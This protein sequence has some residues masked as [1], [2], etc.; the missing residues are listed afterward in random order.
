M[1]FSV[2]IFKLFGAA[3]LFAFLSLALTVQVSAQTTVEKVTDGDE[4]ADD[5]QRA[6]D[7]R[8]IEVLLRL[9]NI[10]LNEKP[11]Y[12]EVVLRHLSRIKGTDRYL[13]L[14]EQFKVADVA[15]DLLQIVAEK[16]DV[17]AGVNAARLLLE[18]GKIAEL[19]KAVSSEDEQLAVAAVQAVGAVGSK[20]SLDL[21]R[22]LITSDKASTS[23]RNQAVR[24]VGKARRGQ[25]FLLRLVEQGEMPEELQFSFANVLLSSR[26]DDIREPASKKLSLPE[27]ADAKPL[28]TVPELVALQGDAQIGREIFAKKGTCA[29]CHKVLGEGKDVGPDLSEIGRK[30]S[31]EAMFVSILNPSEGISHNYETFFV[32]LDSGLSETGLLVS[33][34]DDEV[35]IK[36]KEGIVRKFPRAEIVEFDKD[37]KSIMPEGLQKVLTVEELVSLVDYLQTL[38][39]K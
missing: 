29:N 30:L 24:A 4:N 14:V 31:R 6:K 35:T 3:L 34:T 5:E 23:V 19:Q 13:E 28:P 9:P 32:E 18:F 8:M 1:R 11:K 37:K 15:E 21:V 22:P 2:D 12:K 7:E 39:K 26:F 27:T 33:E 36:N 17:S 10:D 25:A 20:E 16:P 38:T